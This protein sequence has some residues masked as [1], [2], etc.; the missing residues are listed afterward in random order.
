MASALS[1]KERRKLLAQRALEGRD[2]MGTNHKAMLKAHVRDGDLPAWESKIMSRKDPNLGKVTVYAN[3]FKLGTLAQVH[4]WKHYSH[5]LPMLTQGKLSEQLV[6][7]CE[8]AWGKSFASGTLSI[9]DRFALTATDGKEDEVG[10]RGSPRSSTKF[11]KSFALWQPN[12]AVSFMHSNASKERVVGKG[13]E[14]DTVTL[15]LVTFPRQRVNVT[16][17]RTFTVS[18]LYTYIMIKTGQTK[19][20]LFWGFPSNMLT[21]L[22][23]TLYDSGLNGFGVVQRVPEQF[24]NC[25]RRVWQ[26]EED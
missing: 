26:E 11:P 8:E 9:T 6:E 17:P 15:Q 24:P 13:A 22:D 10:G 4:E 16:F 18:E 5:V 20:G 12:P 21:D 19:F 7:A 2:A 25:Y 23:A 3:G 1:P 14:G